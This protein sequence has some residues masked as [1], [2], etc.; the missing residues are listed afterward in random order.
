[1]TF[2]TDDRVY[3]TSTTTGTGTYTL[4]GAVTGFAAFSVMSAGNTCP[5]FATDDTNWE[6]GIGT[7]GTGPSTLARTTVLASSNA[8]AAVNWGSGTRKIRCGL[9]ADMAIPRALSKSVAGSAD[10]TLTSDEQR[11]DILVF[12]GLLTGNISVI[13]DATVWGW[14]VVYNNTTGSFTLTV[15]V[16]GQTGVVVP[17]KRAVPLYCDGTDVEHIR[18]AGRTVAR[19]SNTVLGSDNDRD[20]IVATSTF[21]QTLDAAATLGDGWSVDY[22]NDGTGIITLD[23]NSTEQ[24]DGATTINLYAGES[25]RIVCTGAAFKTVGRST[26]QV[27]IQTQT[28]SGSA[29]IDFTIGVDSKFDQYIIEFDNVLPVTDS[30]SLVLQISQDAGSNWKSGASDYQWVRHGSYSGSASATMAN[31]SAD[32]S[33]SV[34]DGVLDSNT[35]RPLS[36]EIKFYNPSAGRTTNFECRS[37]FY[38]SHLGGTYMGQFNNSGAYVTDGNAINGVRLK[39]SSGN[40]SLGNFR[41]YGVR[42]A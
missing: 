6:V 39:M 30:V 35:G 23:P 26:G 28:A 4:D 10:V 32:A 29:T 18:G 5:Y 14:P 21:T 22:R 17:Q 1:M 2:K 12:T 19:S 11:R 36:G 3:E 13:V 8:G 7:I 24:I 25:C 27:L 41:L 31:D 34:V 42:K 9:P 40:I 20:T 37:T 33:I 16:S 38:T 15:K